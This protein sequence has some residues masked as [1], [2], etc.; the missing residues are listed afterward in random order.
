MRA[1]LCIFREIQCHP[2]AIKEVLVKPRNED[3]LKFLKDE[4]ETRV[5]WIYIDKATIGGLG[6]QCKGII[7]MDTNSKLHIPYGNIIIE[8]YNNNYEW[9]R[10]YS[11]DSDDICYSLPSDPNEILFITMKD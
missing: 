2:W 7:Y 3:F 4:L 5:A 10:I 1:K 11:I 9:N 6:E 8:G